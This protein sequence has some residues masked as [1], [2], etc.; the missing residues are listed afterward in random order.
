[1]RRN[2][3]R[4]ASTYCLYLPISLFSWLHLPHDGEDV[5]AQMII[6]LLCCTTVAFE[7]FRLVVLA[8][9]D[10]VRIFSTI[11]APC[12]IVQPCG[13]SLS[14][15]VSHAVRT[16]EG[17]FCAVFFVCHFSPKKKTP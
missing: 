3:G 5:T 11:D 8:C 9:R 17:F 7:C 13:S 16:W 4:L 1:M 6:A 15:V 12:I 10:G 2:E 14:G